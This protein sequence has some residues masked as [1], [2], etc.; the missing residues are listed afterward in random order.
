M[1]SSARVGWKKQGGCKLVDNEPK[2]PVL[3]GYASDKGWKEVTMLAAVQGGGNF[4]FPKEQILLVTETGYKVIKAEA[5][6][7]LSKLNKQKAY[8]VWYHHLLPVK[9]W[10]EKLAQYK[11]SKS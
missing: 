11:K 9:V 4:L 8:L 2:P 5:D 3:K 1:V 7:H 10:Q 6:R